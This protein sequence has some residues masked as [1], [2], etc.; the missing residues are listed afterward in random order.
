MELTKRYV[1]AVTSCLPE[2][3]RDEVRKELSASIDDMARDKSGGKKPTENH[4]REVLEELGDPLVVAQQYR[5][6]NDYLI[7]PAVFY[8]YTLLLKRVF[9]VSLPIYTLVF[10]MTYD[11]VF[12]L[13]VGSLITSWGGGLFTVAL[14]ILFWVTALFFVIEK[15]GLKV[16]QI[17]D[18]KEEWTVDSLPVV[19]NEPQINRTD[20]ISSMI[21]Y[22]FAVVGSVVLWRL[23]DQG[24][25]S[26]VV[27]TFLNPQ[28]TQFWLPAFLVLSAITFIVEMVKL[29][30]GRWNKWL[31]VVALSVNVAFIVYMI[32]LAGSQSVVNTALN[33]QIR[34]IGIWSVGMTVV[35][36]IFSYAYEAYKIIKS[37]RS[38]LEK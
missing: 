30:K 20:T 16:D 5:G 22:A 25:Q 7:G 24:D 18:Q 10:A 31:V 23:I 3:Q 11:Y 12:P 13:N 15:T 38:R 8:Q 2:N 26:N 1:H 33:P 28:L 17:N 35:A 29:I 36:F 27:A 34:E 21:F 6:T 32:G 9:S 4:V 14:Q 19:P 37:S